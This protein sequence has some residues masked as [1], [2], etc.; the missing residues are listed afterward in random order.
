MRLV[1]ASLSPEAVDLLKTPGSRARFLDG[2][3]MII[4]FYTEKLTEPALV[5]RIIPPFAGMFWF[6][7]PIDYFLPVSALLDHWEEKKAAGWTVE[8]SKE[9]HI[10]MHCPN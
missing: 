7:E 2:W 8:Q 3:T 4:V 9:V 6:K 1:L 5:V 10:G